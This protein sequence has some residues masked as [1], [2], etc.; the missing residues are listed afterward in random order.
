MRR[1]TLAVCAVCLSAAQAP[2][3]EKVVNIPLA[4][5]VL[6]AGGSGYFEHDGTV[7]GSAATVLSFRVDRLGE[8]LKTL[9]LKDLGGGRITMVSYGPPQ[10]AGGKAP[11]M[12]LRGAESVADVLA[13]LRGVEVVVLA[14][15]KITGKIAGVE[16]RPA[17][18][19]SGRDTTIS[20]LTPTGLRRVDLGSVS[21]VTPTDAAVRDELARALQQP[22]ALGGKA[23]K[24]PVRIGLIGQGRRRVRIGYVAPAPPWEISYRLD[25]TGGQPPTP[26]GK[27]PAPADQPVLQGWVSV[28]NATDLDWRKVLLTLVTGE[29][30][31]DPAQ[32]PR[33]EI[34][35]PLDVPPGHSVMLRVVKSDIQAEQVSI[36][37]ARGES[38]QT[39]RA[40]Y[41][42][43]DT[44]AKLA[45]GVLTV[46]D[47]QDYVGRTRIGPLAKGAGQLL[48]CGQDPAVSVTVAAEPTTRI[49]RASI[50]GGVLRVDRTR[51]VTRTYTIRNTAATG[52]TLIIEHPAQA[53][54]RL[55]EPKE[56]QAPTAGLYRFRTPVKASAEATFAVVAEQAQS[57][58]VA[59]GK[60]PAESLSAVAQ[61][62]AVAE[63]VRE[64]LRK[65]IALTGELARQRQVLAEAADRKR[66]ITAAQERIRQNLQ[67]VGQDSDLGKRYLRKLDEQED[68]IERAD[69]QIR[70]AAFLV[71]RQENLLAEHLQTVKAP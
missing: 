35:D 41:L 68:S 33:F 11:A 63:P 67:L 61:D 65:L 43:N 22:G 3:A 29:P 6:F 30:G 60:A 53:G 49:D 57:E 5:V 46:F 64:A 45:A 20:I 59:L 39:H 31:T 26:K 38:P 66:Q 16:T 62:E 13:R 54:L 42:T 21:S 7:E 18:D 47:G 4:R 52:R 44:G 17:K 51:R 37:D 40:V 58:Q 12:D 8:I 50:D 24:V 1:R 36:C 55:V 56:H 14:P 69:I 28:Q 27:G 25:L 23:P 32:A 19:G 70:E 9:V 15:D 48:R 10:G 71:E 34:R 2:A